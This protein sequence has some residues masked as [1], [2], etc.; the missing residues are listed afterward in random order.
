MRVHKI[1]FSL[2]F[3]IFPILGITQ[4]SDKID[5]ITISHLTKSKEINLYKKIQ[6]SRL[7]KG[8]WKRIDSLNFKEVFI[9]ETII[10]SEKEIDSLYTEYHS[11][12]NYLS[13]LDTLIYRGFKFENECS[14]LEFQ[15]LTKDYEFIKNDPKFTH[16]YTQYCGLVSKH[17]IRK[18][19]RKRLNEQYVF[20]TL[21]TENSDVKIQIIYPKKFN[22]FILKRNKKSNWKPYF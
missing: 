15:Y 16:Y 1:I 13:P 14:N 10:F 12:E 20:K 21:I 8:I 2:T 9:I 5:S 3:I 18:S 22:F 17:D 6:E 11:I 19:L 7:K 4:L